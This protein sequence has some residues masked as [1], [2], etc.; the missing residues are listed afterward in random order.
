MLRKILE[1]HDVTTTAALALYWK[2]VAKSR[3]QWDELAVQKGQRQK[4]LF[5]DD[6]MQQLV[7]QDDM[8][9]QKAREV[10]PIKMWLPLATR[11]R[12]F[13][14]ALSHHIKTNGIQQ[15]ILLGGGL[16]TLATRKE[17]YTHHYGVQFF[18]VDHAALLTAKAALYHAQ[19]IHKN[20]VYI[21]MDYTA[22]DYRETW[23]A[24]GIDFTKPTF[25]LWE[26]NSFYLEKD[27]AL[28]VI[29]NI[30]QHFD[31]VVLAFDYMHG[32]MQEQTAQLD[33]AANQQSLEQTL[34]NFKKNRSPFKTFFKPAELLQTLTALGW[35]IEE[36][37]TAAELA[38]QYE[39]DRD[40]YYTA[41]P[42]SV[43]TCSKGITCAL[44]RE[45]HL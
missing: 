36:Q 3:T 5:K 11:T 20:A 27:R 44:L 24:A 28:A 10:L 13:R 33:S 25:I 30:A 21:G 7:S 29:T 42:Y 23:A 37:H 14:R 18:E 15:V 35:T 1:S 22:V 17:K 2:S 6:I 39:V 43:I 4:D 12:F 26:G 38:Q 19:G 40:P 16:D 8:L 45:F 34:T 41:K 9:A 31:H 32:A